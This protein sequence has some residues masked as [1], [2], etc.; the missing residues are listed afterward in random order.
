MDVGIQSALGL[1][2][3]NP[4]PSSWLGRADAPSVVPSWANIG[5]LTGTQIRSLLAQIGYDLSAWNYSLVGANN[6]LGRYQINTSTLE[7]YG[8]LAPGSNANFGTDCVNYKICWRPTV[9]NNGINV[10]QNYFYNITSIQQFFTVTQAQD[11]LAYQILADL[12]AA[13]INAEVIYP[14][15]SA[16]T[17]AGMLYVCWTLGVGTSASLNTPGGTGAWA[18]RNL[19]FGINGTSSFNSGRYAATVLST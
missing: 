14:T 12:Y 4:L 13:A 1:P 11:H 15:D 19:N 16:D 17:V 10:Y 5:V 6:Q 3:A 8:L 9:V 7:L 18:W 2:I